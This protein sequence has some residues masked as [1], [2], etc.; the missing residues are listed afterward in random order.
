VI[1]SD[2]VY[3]VQ[4]EATLGV[5]CTLPNADDGGGGSIAVGIFFSV[6]GGGGTS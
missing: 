2:L 1:I 4:K 5:G 6:V 3:K